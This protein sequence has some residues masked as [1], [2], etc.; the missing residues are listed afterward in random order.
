MERAPSLLVGSVYN[1]FFFSHAISRKIVRHFLFIIYSVEMECIFCLGPRRPC[2]N[3]EVESRR[4]LDGDRRPRRL[5]QVLATQHEQRQDV[6]GTQGASQRHLV[7]TNRRQIR[8]MLR[9]RLSQ[10][11]GLLHVSTTPLLN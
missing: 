2:A 4:H 10:D 5:H 1:D 7:L 6:P 11:M 9:R 8:L 3:D